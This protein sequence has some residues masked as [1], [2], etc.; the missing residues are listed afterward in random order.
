MPLLKS[1]PGLRPVAIFDEI[2]VAIPATG[3]STVLMDTG[4]GSNSH[5]WHYKP[6]ASS[7]SRMM[8]TSPES[9][10]GCPGDPKRVVPW[11]CPQA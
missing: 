8:V 7:S 10:Q 3:N 9:R 11:H 6:N 1:A 4:Q 2:G 5:R